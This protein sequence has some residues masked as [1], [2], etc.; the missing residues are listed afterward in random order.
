MA[1]KWLYPPWQSLFG[2]PKRVE[3]ARQI[4]PAGADR[5]EVSPKKPVTRKKDKHT[6]DLTPAE[7]TKFQS[8]LEKSGI[9]DSDQPESHYDYRGYFKEH[10]DKPVKFGEEHF[11]DRY[12][13][14]PHPTF[15]RESKYSQGPS[16]G[17]TW[18]AVA[19]K[20]E[21]KFKPAKHQKLKEANESQYISSVD[22]K[23]EYKFTLKSTG[24]SYAMPWDKDKPPSALE[25]RQYAWEKENPTTMQRV[26]EFA[27]K[28]L[29]TA[30]SRAAQPVAEKLYQY[31]EGKESGKTR[32]GALARGAGAYTES[33][34]GTLDSQTNLLN[35]GLTGLSLGSGT[36]LKFGLPKT[37]SAFRKVNKAA[38]AGMVGHGGYRV[39]DDPTTEGK[40][41]G[42]IE[43]VLGAAGLYAGRGGTRTRPQPEGAPLNRRLGTGNEPPTPPPNFRTRGTPKYGPYRTN[44]PRTDAQGRPFTEGEF[45]ESGG[46]SAGRSNRPGQVE[47]LQLPPRSQSSPSTPQGR[48][49]LR[50][51]PGG[52]SEVGPVQRPG[53]PSPRPTFFAGRYGVGSSVDQASTPQTTYR[54]GV[55]DNPLLQ[56]VEQPPIYE[57]PPINRDILEQNSPYGMN[58]QRGEQ[59]G[60]ARTESI[61]P[62]EP[63]PTTTPGGGLKKTVYDNLSDADVQSL[64]DM[65]DVD[66]AGELIRRKPRQSLMSET[67]AVGRDIRE[68][69]VG[70]P[71]DPSRRNF[72]KTLRTFLDPWQRASIEEEVNDLLNTQGGDIEDYL[73]DMRN[74]D[75]TSLSPEDRYAHAYMLSR[76]AEQGLTPQSAHDMLMDRWQRKSD[77]PV[78]A[79][80]RPDKVMVDSKWVD[81][82][83]ADYAADSTQRGPL[84]RQPRLGEV[85]EIGPNDIYE[86]EDPLPARSVKG[87]KQGIVIGA[88]IKRAAAEVTTGYSMPLERIMVRE[89]LQN[90]VDAVEPLGDQGKISITTGAD[91]IEISDNGPGMTAK[92]LQTV[93]SNIHETGKAGVK[94]AGGGKGVGKLSY[95]LGGKHFEV[96]TVVQEGRFLTRYT[97]KGTPEE[98]STHVDLDSEPATPGTPTGT[99]FKTQF[100]E[101]QDSYET[102]RMLRDIMRNSRGTKARITHLKPRQVYSWTADKSPFEID[103][104]GFNTGIDDK[105]VGTAQFGLDKVDIR[106]SKE[107]LAQLED[108][109][110]V[111][112][113]VLNKGVYQYDYDLYLG[114]ETP[115]MPGEVIVD[116]FPDAEEGT[117]EYPF[118]T[119]R[120]A[121][122]SELRDSIDNLIKTTLSNPQQARKKSRLAELYA[123][124]K[125]MSA[126]TG[127][128]RDSAIFDS[129]DRLTPQELQLFKDSPVTLSL[130]EH[131]DEV[132]ADM[133][134]GRMSTTAG[135]TRRDPAL[136]LP[137]AWGDRL[138]KTGLIL[139]EG[140][141][142]IHIPNPDPAQNKSTILINY[143]AH[144]ENSTPEDAAFNATITALHEGAHIDPST[145]VTPGEYLAKIDPKEL[146]DPRI[147]KY[148][149]SY[150]THASEQ[151]GLD[152][153]HLAWTKR[154][155]EIYANFGPKRFFTSVDKLLDI[156][157]DEFGEY[158]PE[159]QRLLSVYKESR[160]RTAVT[161]D[162]LSRTGVKQAI[163]EAGEGVFLGPDKADGAGFA[164]RFK[165]GVQD[166]IDDDAGELRFK[167]KSR[168]YKAKQDTFRG[169]FADWV[170]KRK[171]SVIEGVLK[172]RDFKDLDYLGMQGIHDF[173]SGKRTGRLKA[174]QD[175]FDKKAEEL[176]FWGV[177]ADYRENYVPQIWADDPEKVQAVFR[178]LG[179]KP[180]FTLKRVFENYQAGIKHGLTPRFDKLSDLINW[181]EQ[182]A[183]KAIADRQFYDYAKDMNWIKPLGKGGPDWKHLD[184][185]FFPSIRVKSKSSNEVRTLPMTASPELHEMITNYLGDP[186][187]QIQ[188]AADAASLSKNLA[189]SSGVPFTGINAH[190]F[191]I[192]ARTL[193]GNPKALLTNGKYI[194][195]PKSAG[196]FLDQNLH[197]APEAVR[198]GLSLTT[199]GHEMGVVGS[200][201]LTGKLMEGFFKGQGKM[202]EDPLFQNIIP[203]LKLKHWADMTEDLVKSGMGRE[204]AKRKAAEMSNDLYGGFNWEALGRSRDL[205]NLKRAIILAPDWL[206]TN[207]R[208]GKGIVK[209]V[210][211]PKNPLGRQ[212]AKIA[213]NAI[214]AYIAADLVNYMK[215][216]HHMWENEPGHSLDIQFGRSGD[217]DRYIRPFGT[218]ADFVRLPVDGISALF[219]GDL[220]QGFRIAKNRLSIPGNTGLNFLGNQDDFGKPLYG[221]DAYGR[222]IPVAQQAT[223]MLGEV[224]DLFTP[225]YIA[226]SANYA[227]GRLNL[228]QAAIGAVESPVRYAR[229]RRSGPAF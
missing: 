127:T 45:Y 98:F 83:P 46:G 211:D 70:S 186:N 94:G 188:F 120:E 25:A 7:E 128:E 200:T 17:G 44:E 20:D 197:R 218:A 97:A 170:N 10:G 187:Q 14:P 28:P 157:T 192:L 107:M 57:P 199:E 129:G 190:G 6:T 180:S 144:M 189:M 4:S 16:H 193:I 87:G 124:M 27:E 42:G 183:N 141:L 23:R 56:P 33:L 108:R 184:A 167:W 73:A 93:F 115:E 212:Y 36:A 52:G 154:L 53:L 86:P 217:S 30:F 99:R 173:Q 112:V 225:P 166:F 22:K 177:K 21:E 139:D 194:F 59:R 224:S 178:R 81:A 198:S 165:R 1:N 26:S 24:K 8:W 48:A 145:R 78:R 84:E 75:F 179:L 149:Q 31:G 210:L 147:G 116:I 172:G 37:A 146:T 85:Q 226:S 181:Y 204:A 13:K 122:K 216:G 221:R 176:D 162:I 2:K 90:A 207:Y 109:F 153:H 136:S 3:K 96:E 123:N 9:T 213:R 67:G 161:E 103:E 64:S 142:G 223:G 196:K 39:Y 51:G 105:I 47:P 82:P 29:T 92:E 222:K 80:R 202:F 174:V 185:N 18:E 206:T 132:F 119:A 111:N 35:L 140:H 15:S 60:L 101:G 201:N 215:N 148:L 214:G 77:A 65:G 12:K 151:G 195:Y 68:K 74:T 114:S 5:P 61:P 159:V 138:E 229:R 137:D 49:P 110:S 182:K 19:G 88:N 121:V 89:G 91:F 169:R 50:L 130:L 55:G 126:Q 168:E 117:D 118:N 95:I 71:D 58:W 134:E 76:G 11:T 63:P 102:N 41:G 160:G 72:L 69:R 228:E 113:A 205:N 220:G 125:D 104:M 219:Q 150:L 152:G 175:Y 191:N 156:T 32:L 66:A 43:A 158:R 163:R 155:G 106:V 34:G 131:T 79:P 100:K 208:L 62:V 54:G 209:G 133:L 227:S 38:N 203:A 135:V 40:I 171:A 164:D 143:F